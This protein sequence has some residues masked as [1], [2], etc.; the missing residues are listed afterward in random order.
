MS[1]RSP[2]AAHERKRGQLASSLQRAVQELLIR[3]IND[4]RLVGIITVTGVEVASDLA[5]ATVLVSVMPEKSEAKVLGGLKHSA[6]FIRREVGNRID[7]ARLPTLSF[8]IDRSLK[9]QAGI[10]EAL[11]KVAAEREAKGLAAVEP[12]EGESADAGLDGPDPAENNG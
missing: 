5:T 7:T 3:G 1:G 6:G 11:S 4:P 10:I 2:H 12:G 8:R 9:R